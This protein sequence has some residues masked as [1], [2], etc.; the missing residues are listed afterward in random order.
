MKANWAPRKL[1]LGGCIAISLLFIAYPTVMLGIKS[2]PLSNYGAQLQSKQAL[3]AIKNTL[4]ISIGATTIATVLGLT[5]AFLVTRTDMPF[6]RLINGG[7]YL[8]FLTP[9]YIG[10][11]AWIQLL[12]RS[13][14]LTRWIQSHLT[15]QRA[16][17]DIYTLEAATI[18]MGLYLMPLVY[19]AASNAF[20]KVDPSLE[21]AA[22]T[23]GAKPFRTILTVTIPLALPG[24]LSAAL[25]VF[26][27]GMSG[28]GIPAALAMPAGNMVLRTQIY[29]ALGHY[30]VNMACALSVMLVAALGL[31]MLL[32]YRLLHKKRHAVN[33]SP[34][35]EQCQLTLGG[36][37]YLIAVI[38]L[39]F[40]LAFAVLPLIT[41]FGTSLLKAWGLPISFENLT[42]GNYISIFSVGVGARALRNS[43]L[44]ALAG[45]FCA[46]GLGFF[47]AYISI[48]TSITG[49][50]FLDFLAMIP[51][52]IPGPVLAAAMIF[53]F[54]MP[55]LELYNTPWIIFVAYVVAFLPYA[56]RNISGG[57]KSLNPQ[58]EEMGWM[59]GSPWLKNLRQVV[60]PGLRG[61][62]WS[63]WIIVFLMAFRE[64]PISSMLYIN[65]S[66]TVGVLLFI[67][68][69]EAGGP[70]VTSAVSV[71]VMLLTI[72]GQTAVRQL[73]HANHNWQFEV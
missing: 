14:Y 73:T 52:T 67:L 41:I 44:Y 66:E 58:L 38:L 63:S 36:W 18:F 1:I 19:M 27:H 12:G 71:V 8:V 11:L 25:L 33:P 23:A 29:A 56:V 47:I 16:P 15:L 17:I 49:R 4:Y 72:L 57:I 3:L 26:I 59:C 2:L 50:K 9:G 42:L 13:G 21:E 28:F 60:L 54:S 24:T 55:P 61:N 45:A 34:N 30:D 70:E 62:L 5:L 51:S 46:V 40:L 7:V 69:T 64:I 48:R 65:G 32:Y 39:A 10:T 68:K 31:T 43:F 53:A 22:L 6:K 37:R 20:M 35:L